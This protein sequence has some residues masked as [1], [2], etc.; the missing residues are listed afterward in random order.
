MTIAERLTRR[1]FNRMV[2]RL[3]NIRR[4]VRFTDVPLG[5][6]W[7]SLAQMQWSAPL[8]LQTLLAI[9]WK[10]LLASGG[11]IFPKATSPLAGRKFVLDDSVIQMLGTM[12]WRHPSDY[13]LPRLYHQSEVDMY[14]EFLTKRVGLPMTLDDIRQLALCA[15]GIQ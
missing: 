12:H 14:F 1:D 3:R 2:G 6:Y 11:V 4:R 13:A 7:A 10:R 5:I 9:Q 15:H 8:P